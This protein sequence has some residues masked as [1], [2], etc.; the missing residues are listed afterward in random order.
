[1]MN[2]SQFIHKIIAVSLVKQATQQYKTT[3]QSTDWESVVRYARQHIH[4]PA[5]LSWVDRHAQK[6]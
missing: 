1:M 2:H 6:E 3:G 5:F 4:C